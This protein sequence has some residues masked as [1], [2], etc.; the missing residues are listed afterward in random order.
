MKLKKKIWI[1]FEK[2]LKHIFQGI[3]INF[4]VFLEKFWTNWGNIEKMLIFMV[5]EA[6]KHDLVKWQIP[7]HRFVRFDDFNYGRFCTSPIR[8]TVHCDVVSNTL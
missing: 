1:K 7:V 6:Y 3:A 4:G 8:P 2:N 5:N